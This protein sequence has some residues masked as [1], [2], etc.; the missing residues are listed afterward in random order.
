MIIALV[1]GLAVLLSVG[2]AA[3]VDPATFSNPTQITNPYFPL[4]P[5][6]TLIYDGKKDGQPAHS[7]VVV[8]H[9]TGSS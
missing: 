2:P 7:D 3:A 9:K 8:T 1:T 5:G 4:R 6:T